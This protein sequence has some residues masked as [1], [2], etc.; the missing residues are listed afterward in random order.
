M[1]DLS[2]EQL[3]SDL[4]GTHCP[5][6]VSVDGAYQLGYLLVCHC[7]SLLMGSPCVSPRD[8]RER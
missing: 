7:A 8:M 6:E 3:V 1:P 4:P 2:L 5:I